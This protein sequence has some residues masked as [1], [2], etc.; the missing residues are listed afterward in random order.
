MKK[1]SWTQRQCGIDEGI[2]HKSL[3]R[4]RKSRSIFTQI[5]QFDIGQRYKKFNKY[6]FST[7]GIEATANQCAEKYINLN[8]N[9]S[10]KTDLK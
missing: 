3:E 7:S 8:L 9:F 4:K 1:K 5:W 10:Y 6:S 2:A